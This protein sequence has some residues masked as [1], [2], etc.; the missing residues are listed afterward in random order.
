[1]CHAQSSAK[2]CT[3]QPKLPN[4]IAQRYPS[5]ASYPPPVV[6]FAYW[7]A[8]VIGPFCG[9]VAGDG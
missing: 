8:F 5:F 3:H 9:P 7:V 1:M 2:W 4:L 6:R